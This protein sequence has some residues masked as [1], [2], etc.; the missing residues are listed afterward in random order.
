[1]D[2]PATALTN[3]FPEPDTDRV[4]GR[5]GRS[6]GEDCGRLSATGLHSWDEWY[7]LF[8]NCSGSHDHDALEAPEQMAVLIGVTGCTTSS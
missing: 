7:S 6:N 5:S 4:M 3:L 8:L 1:M 2:N